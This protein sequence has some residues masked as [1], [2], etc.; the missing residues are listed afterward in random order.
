MVERAAAISKTNAALSQRQVSVQKK[1]P[2][3][4]ATGFFFRSIEK[5][6]LEQAFALGSLAGQLART[7]HSFGALAGTLF[8]R[9][10]KVGPAFHFPEKAFALHLFL[11]R[12]QGLLDIIVADDDLYDGSISICL[13]WR[14]PLCL[15]T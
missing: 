13:G 11:Q 6:P 8:G 15:A 14:N 3:A 12:A 4:S 7:A 9:L 2:V 1:N 10:F 5:L